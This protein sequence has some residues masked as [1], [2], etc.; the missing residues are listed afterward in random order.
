MKNSYIV[1]LLLFC[2]HSFPNGKFLLGCQFKENSTFWQS[3]SG[4]TFLAMFNI[5]YSKTEDEE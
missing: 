5:S 2:F 4:K 3:F 1:K